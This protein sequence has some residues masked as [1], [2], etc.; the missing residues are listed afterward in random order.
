MTWAGAIVHT[1]KHAE[2]VT[3]LL[4]T[5]LRTAC[6]KLLDQVLNKLLTTC[7]K[8]RGNVTRL[9]TSLFKQDWHSHDTTIL[10]QPCVVNFVTIL[11]QQV[12]IRVVEHV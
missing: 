11:L 9:V 5:F 2:V 8:L 6:S 3:S 7:N 10:L 1:R 12:V 4:T